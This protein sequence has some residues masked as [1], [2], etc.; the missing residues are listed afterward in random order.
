[1][2]GFCLRAFSPKIPSTTAATDSGKPMI[3]SKPKIPK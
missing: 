3:G 2:I 1:M